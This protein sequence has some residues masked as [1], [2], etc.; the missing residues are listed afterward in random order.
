MELLS[1]VFIGWFFTLLSAAAL[2]AGALLMFQLSH[3]GGAMEKR[4]LGYSVWNDVGLGVIWGFGLAGGIGILNMQPW[5]RWL[6]EI[7]CWAVIVLILLSAGNRLYAIKAADPEAW[8]GNRLLA[9]SGA[10]LVVL[11]VVAICA[12]AIYTLRT[13]PASHPLLGS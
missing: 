6:L 2:L 4:Y 3:T 8:P 9:I 12:A 10:M 7:F 1:L 5:G 11:P 13:L